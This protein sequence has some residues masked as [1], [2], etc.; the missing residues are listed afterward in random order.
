MLSLSKDIKGF[1]MI[2]LLI[3][4]A[5]FGFVMPALAAGINNLVVLNNRAR[6][7]S[8]AN[9]IAENKAEELRNSGYNSLSPG[10]VSF[11]NELP[12]E[13]APPKTAVYTVSNPEA[14]LAQVIIDISYQDYNQVKSLSY[15]TNV[16][17]LGVGQ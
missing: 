7:L 3:V 2:E 8:L 14:G 6:D 17:E 9:I 12:K 4:I 1:T 15:K 11:S 10:T 16:S 13:L 5:I